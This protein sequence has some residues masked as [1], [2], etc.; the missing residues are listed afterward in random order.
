LSH[1]GAEGAKALGE[2]GGGQAIAGN[3]LLVE[4]LELLEVTAFETFE[5]AV[6]S[7]DRRK[8]FE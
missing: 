6:N 4:S 8:G 1:L 7:V 3:S 2:F 5:A